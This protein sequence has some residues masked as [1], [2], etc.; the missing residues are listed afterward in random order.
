VQD[1]VFDKF[2]QML[3]WLKLC[4]FFEVIC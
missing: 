4:G 3:I 1:K 2:E